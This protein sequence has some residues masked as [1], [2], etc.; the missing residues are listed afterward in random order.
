M[1][2][3][4]LPDLRNTNPILRFIEYYAVRNIL[5][6]SKDDIMDE[7]YPSEAAQYHE[8]IRDMG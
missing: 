6:N 8:R 3:N 4:K 1:Y 5:A 7:R 2:M